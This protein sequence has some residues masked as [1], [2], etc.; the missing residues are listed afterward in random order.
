MELTKVIEDKKGEIG[1]LEGKVQSMT[2]G[3]KMMNSNTEILNEIIEKG[4]KSMS[5]S[6][7][8]CTVREA[9]KKG[10]TTTRWISSTRAKFR[11]QVYLE[12]LSLR[13]KMS[14]CP[15]LQQDLWKGTKHVLSTQD[16]VG[17]ERINYEQ[18]CVYLSGGNNMGRMVVPKGRFTGKGCLSVDRLSKLENVLLVDGLTVNLISISN[19]CDEGMKVAFTKEACAVSNNSNKLIMKGTRSSDNCYIW[20]P[21]KAI[22]DRPTTKNLYKPTTE[23]FSN[24]CPNKLSGVFLSLRSKKKST[25]NVKYESKLSS[26]TKSRGRNESPSSE[27]KVIMARNLRTPS[28]MNSAVQKA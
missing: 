21:H 20:F 10:P 19:L 9:R 7:I 16:A 22:L 26:L 6:G 14:H 11:K 2:S 3:I 25:L 17:K 5:N 24:L 13:K 8:D 1:I 15:L 18:H 12:M 27:S 23:I 4:K 28:S